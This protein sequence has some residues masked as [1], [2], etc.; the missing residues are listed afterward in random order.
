MGLIFETNGTIYDGYAVLDST[1]G[2]AKG[3]ALVLDKN[4]AAAYMAEGAAG[5]QPRP[6]PDDLNGLYNIYVVGN[7]NAA[8]V[9]VSDLPGENQDGRIGVPPG[10]EDPGT[11]AAAYPS[12]L[13]IAN[14]PIPDVAAVYPAEVDDADPSGS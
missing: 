8:K 10:V 11:G 1:T 3:I 2:K 7:D 14:E 5:N 4:G 6:I 13:G 12:S 9:Q